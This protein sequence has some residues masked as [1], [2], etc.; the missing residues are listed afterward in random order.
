[1][2]FLQAV[3]R[4]CRRGGPVQCRGGMPD[5]RRTHAGQGVAS[6]H[7]ATSSGPS[8]TPRA[9]AARASGTCATAKVHQ[10]F[11]RARAD[12]ALRARARTWGS[13]QICQTD[14]RDSLSFAGTARSLTPY[15]R[16]TPSVSDQ[17]VNAQGINAPPLSRSHYLSRGCLV[18]TRAIC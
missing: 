1:M 7:L 17:V 12:A 13:A 8:A 11:A 3:D 10:V 15:Y 14:F 18:L 4:A 16:S 5:G 2:S 9:R 6:T